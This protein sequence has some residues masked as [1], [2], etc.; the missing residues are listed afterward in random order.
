[1]NEL[2]GI[3]LRRFRQIRKDSLI[4]NQDVI[5]FIDVIYIF[6]NYARFFLTSLRGTLTG[7]PS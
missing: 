7:T 2:A 3:R 4:L 5:C 6:D 1:M